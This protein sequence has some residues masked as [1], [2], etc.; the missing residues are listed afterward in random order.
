MPDRPLNVSS[1]IFVS[2]ADA[3]AAFYCSVFGA[4]VLLRN[5]LPSGRVLFVE[6]AFGPAKLMISDEFPEIGGS[7][8]PATGGSSALLLLEVEDVDGAAA[9][10]LAAGAQ[11]EM[12]ITEMFWGERYGILRDPFG[13]RWAIT[14]HRDNLDPAEVAQ[15]HAPIPDDWPASFP[16]G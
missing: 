7:P 5:A 3:A 12:A 2:D 11:I 14:T 15:R 8:P 1:H 9:L 16:S 4:S 10:A 13:H 6:L